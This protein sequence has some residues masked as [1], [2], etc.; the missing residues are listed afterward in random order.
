MNKTNIAIFIIL[1]AVIAAY[2]KFWRKPS[3]DKADKNAQQ[4]A[5]S[6][7]SS[8]TGST[9][10]PNK[11]KDNPNAG[12][13][14]AGT[15]KNLLTNEQIKEIQKETNERIK[16]A[17]IYT[18]DPKKYAVFLQYLPQSTKNDILAKTASASKLEYI[19]VDG[20]LG[21]S[22]IFAFQQVFSMVINK[23]SDYNQIKALWQIEAEKS[24]WQ[25]GKENFLKGKPS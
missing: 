6:G 13:A 16:A 24:Y 9:N 5:Q 15:T 4:G 3:D 22:T 20:S 1:L 7:E 11:D 14:V 2:F 18:A 17:K 21:K 12:G 10:T 25:I 8:G 23:N 19:K